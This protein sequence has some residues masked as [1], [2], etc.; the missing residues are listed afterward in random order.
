MPSRTGPV[1]NASGRQSDDPGSNP[2]RVVGE[3]IIIGIYIDTFGKRQITKT[4][5][6]NVYL[7]KTEVIGHTEAHG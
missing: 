7:K 4:Q 5:P 3:S 1:G 6:G 2:P